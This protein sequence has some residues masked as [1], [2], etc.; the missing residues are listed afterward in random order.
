[1]AE[2]KITKRLC[3]EIQLFDLCGKDVCRDKDGRFCANSEMIAKFEA[4]SEEETTDANFLIQDPEALDDYDDGDDE[5]YP[6]DLDDLE[7]E[8]EER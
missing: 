7:D 4:I 2:D 5:G 1:M 8:F 3:S 6:D